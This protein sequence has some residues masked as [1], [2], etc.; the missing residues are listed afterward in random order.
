MIIAKLRKKDKSLT[1]FLSIFYILLFVFL[2]G[3]QNVHKVQSRDAMLPFFQ[4]QSD[5]ALFFLS[6][7]NFYTSVLT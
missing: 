2:H 3:H 1:I 4:I 7:L 5:T 6:M